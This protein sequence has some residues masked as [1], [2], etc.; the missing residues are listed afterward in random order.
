[1]ANK[2]HGQE[3]VK[4]L[5]IAEP[6]GLTRIFDN[7]TTLSVV[8]PSPLPTLFGLRNGNN[9]EVRDRHGRTEGRTFLFMD[10]NKLDLC[11]EGTEKTVVDNGLLGNVRIT[12]VR[13]TGDALRKRIE[14]TPNR[15]VID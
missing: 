15:K 1:M 9:L 11:G 10:E 14:A 12:L 13:G 7:R 4:T 6:M 5:V 3:L 2:V 8:E